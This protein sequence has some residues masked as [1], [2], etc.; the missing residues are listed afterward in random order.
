[1]AISCLF[2]GAVPSKY[3]Y[4]SGVIF[5]PSTP[6]VFSSVSPLTTTTFEMVST[7]QSASQPFSARSD[8]TSAILLLSFSL[9]SGTMYFSIAPDST[10]AA[11]HSAILIQPSSLPLFIVDEIFSP[12]ISIEM[13]MKN[14]NS[15]IK[16]RL[17]L[18]R[19]SLTAMKNTGL[20]GFLPSLMMPFFLYRSPVVPL[21]IASTGVNFFTLRVLT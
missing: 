8:S 18:L 2:C 20:T 15:I 9:P 10:T 19:M 6:W 5:T 16:K 21:R 12:I 14:V 13:P 17:G 11:S 1:M 4:S 7:K 3:R